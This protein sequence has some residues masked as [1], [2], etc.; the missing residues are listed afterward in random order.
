MHHKNAFAFFF[1]FNDQFSLCQC[2][3]WVWKREIFKNVIFISTLALER[4]AQKKMNRITSLGAVFIRAI[5]ENSVSIYKWKGENKT[6]SNFL[7]IFSKPNFMPCSNDSADTLPPPP[8]PPPPTPRFLCPYIVP[9]LSPQTTVL[10]L[11]KTIKNSPP[12]PKT[13]VP[14]K[15]RWGEWK[16]PKH[17]PTSQ[18]KNRQSRTACDSW[19]DP[20]LAD[21]M[22]KC[23]LCMDSDL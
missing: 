9:W 10:K 15:P 12:F 17:S 6:G 13:I 22:I 4:W 5:T 2:W 7:Y 14:L 16:M 3:D 11:N 23:P 21:P 20:C 19:I 8:H 18:N 1:F